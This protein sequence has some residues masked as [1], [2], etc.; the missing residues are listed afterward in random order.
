[1][2]RMLVD[3]GPLRARPDFRRLWIGFAVSALGTQLSVVAVSLDVYLITRSNLD[4]GLIS[5][6]QLGPA[7]AGSILGGSI[8]D[9]IDRRKLLIGT[10][11]AMAL[12]SS[13]LALESARAHPSL[14][15]IYALAGVSAMF[16]GV[17]SPALVAV[18][19]SIV[20]REEMVQANA[21]RQLSFQ[22]STVIGP[23][24]AGP[25]ITAFKVPTLF[26]VNA[27]TF[28]VGVGAVMTVGSRPPV[29]GATKFGLGS[30]L[31][32]FAYLRGRQAIQGCFVADLNATILGMPTAL[33][34]AL[35][36]THF[37]GGDGLVG[38]LYATP[39]I[40]ALVASVASGWTAR[41]QRPGRAVVIA[42]VIWGVGLTCFGLVR[43]VPLALVALAVAGGA[44]VISAVFRSTIV[45]V[46]TPDRLRGRLS[47]IQ[48]AVVTSG[49]R[50]GNA[51]AGLMAAATSTTFSVVSGG[52]GCL[53]GIAI[54]AK[55][56][57]RFVHFRI[58]DPDTFDH[59]RDEGDDTF[60]SKADPAE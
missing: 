50:L 44:D 28:L 29:G 31:E 13:G 1:M 17:N 58:D 34:P 47:S 46:E 25:L 16:Q 36:L 12:L 7:L 51:E 10:G 19:L 22:L 39:G 60:S 6:V 48:Q 52:L 14:L 53:V 20:D 49:P 24:I 33:F 54:I 56:M 3:L 41:V 55:A 9:A 37:H 30:I 43:W 8:A 15:A 2:A 11:T 4:V 59:A 18:L 23:S 32:G 57:P 26:W 42:I 40:G 21:L 5:I 35:A 27:A 38:V 45:Q